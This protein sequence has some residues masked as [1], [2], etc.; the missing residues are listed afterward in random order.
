MLF[1]EMLDRRQ[2][3]AAAVVDSQGSVTYGEFR[4]AVAGFAAHLHDMG[5][6]K[7]DRVA[8][9]GYNSA[10]WLVAFFAIVRA[11]GVA[12]LVN[13]SMGVEDAA[14]LLRT[15]NA[16]FLIC[17]DNGQTRRRDDAMEALADAAGIERS[18]CVDA[19]SDACKLAATYARAEGLAEQR[20]PNEETDTAFII[21]TSGTT[22]APKAVCVSQRA[23]TAD[24][25]A[26]VAG[27]EA[28][29]GSSVCV[30]VPLFHILG[31]LTSYV[32]LILGS[33][34]CLPTS[35]R[36]DTLVRMVSENQVSDM[37]AVG[38]VYQGLAD[39]DGFAEKVVPHLRT[40]LIA[41]GMSTPVQMMRLELDFANATFINM[42]GQSEGAPLTMVRPSDLV[43]LRANT[44]GRA[45]DGVEL[46][47]ASLD[48]ST[49]PIGE[50]GEVLARG[51]CLMNGYEG[52]PS[53]KQAIDANG[54]LHTG[55]LGFL[56]SSGYLHLAGR[57]K[58]VIIRGGENISPA[59]IEA[60]LTSI[61]G[62]ADAKVMGAPHAIFGESVEACVTAQET[63]S[64]DAGRVL[65]ALRARMPRYKVPAHVFLYREF[66]LNVNGKL[67]Q[68]SLYVSMLG[69]LRGIEVDEELAGGITVFEITVKNSSYAIGPVTALVDDL[70]SSIGYEH[71]RAA[72][73]RL[74]V[75]EMLIERIMYAYS[76]AGDIHVRIA[77]MPEWLRVSF[78]DDGAEYVIDKRR[79]T[80]TS[81]RI[82]LGSVDNFHT[83]RRDGK[84]EYCM[85]FLYDD[86]LDV[87]GFLLRDKQTAEKWEEFNEALKLLP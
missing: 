31:L 47:I 66:P 80:S 13:Y 15:A 32:Y 77:L 8:L 26:L 75:E 56:D 83:E 48:G 3:G 71:R 1:S 82:I 53:D 12:L 54:W 38:A 4:A 35:Y 25:R 28:T 85:D 39:A 36:A 18:R 73:I 2:D 14:G 50:V 60:E 20:R 78:S 79:D 45:V 33:V 81:A 59:E 46:R 62:V 76:G 49:L 24:A 44:V 63:A 30:A 42:Y 41:G 43:E 57:I 74:A 72:K 11:G 40:C 37:A 84:P 9:W 22:S 21:F 87:R 52:L 51:V 29:M 55:D 61:E 16:R 27:L 86:D 69:K 65:E 68:R 6:A 7:G 58:D 70:A 19:R 10:N 34:V 17:G 67:D 23:L 5:L 64:F